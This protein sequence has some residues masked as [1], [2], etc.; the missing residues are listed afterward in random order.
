M[1]N[2]IFDGTDA[3][4]LSQETAVGQHPVEAVE[5][6]ASIADRHRARAARTAAS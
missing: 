3:V 2:A 6:M 5:M 4:M 1:A